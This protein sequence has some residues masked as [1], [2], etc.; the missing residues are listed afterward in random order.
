MRFFTVYD[1]DQLRDLF[2]MAEPGEPF[3][4]SILGMIGGVKRRARSRMACRF[5]A[6]IP[7]PEISRHGVKHVMKM[8]FGI[9]VSD[10]D[11]KLFAKAD[12]TAATKIDMDAV[13]DLA[14][15]YQEHAL[16]TAR[17]FE[18]EWLTV[19][20]IAAATPKKMTKKSA[21]GEAK[22]S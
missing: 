2:A 12:R 17:E 20:E 15:K 3:S 7:F 22:P 16:A 5:C 10:R 4:A 9:A 19:R 21:K 6:D 11:L 18:H 8:L 13:L 1:T 14:Q